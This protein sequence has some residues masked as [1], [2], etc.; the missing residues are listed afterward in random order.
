[1]GRP[2]ET[3]K[4]SLRDSAVQGGYYEWNGYRYVPSWGGSMFEA[5]MPTLVLDEIEH[6]PASLGRNDVA[7]A[8]VQRRYALERLGYP[9][10]G[11]SP[12]VSPQGGYGE[13]GVEVL[14]SRGYGAGAVTPHAAALALSATP[15]DAVANLRRLIALYPIYG[16]YGFYDSVDPVSGEVAHAYLALDQSMVLISI[17]NRLKDHCIQRYFASDPIVQRALPIIADENFFD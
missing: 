7:H 2:V 16:E 11:V 1:M 9:V 12:S 15:E 4:K 3:G 5:L 14:G 8:V 13:Y 10:W 6:A 17:A